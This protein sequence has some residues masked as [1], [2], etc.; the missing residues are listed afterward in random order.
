M[1]GFAP[2]PLTIVAVGRPPARLARLSKVKTRSLPAMLVTA[3][4]SAWALRSPVTSASS[5]T[6]TWRE[7]VITGWMAG[8]NGTG[9]S[10]TM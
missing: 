4:R 8:T 5:S 6:S 9:K 7:R 10:T 1:S 3:A 2:K